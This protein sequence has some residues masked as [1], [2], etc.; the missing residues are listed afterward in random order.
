MHNSPQ[1]KPCDNLTKKINIIIKVTICEVYIS[2]Q[3]FDDS[4]N[5]IGNDI[6]H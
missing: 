3:R 4:G 2:P 1:K 5:F 6:L